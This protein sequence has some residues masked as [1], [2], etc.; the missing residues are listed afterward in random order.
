MSESVDITLLGQQVLHLQ[1]EVRTIKDDIKGMRATMVTR[2]EWSN[3][4]DA[5]MARLENLETG[6]AHAFRQLNEKMD[7]QYAQ[8]NE[9]MDRQ[10][11]AVLA[12]LKKD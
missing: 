7:R 4:H 1:A 6:V 10:H 9:K 3:D 11:T 5:I 12:L 2:Q 8:L